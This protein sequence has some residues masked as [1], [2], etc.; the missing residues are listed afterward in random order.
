ML[1]SISRI[2]THGHETL[3]HPTMLKSWLFGLLKTTP[4][5]WHQAIP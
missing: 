2:L 5:A 4:L 1:G 3:T